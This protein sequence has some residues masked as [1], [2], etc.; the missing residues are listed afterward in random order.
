M[1]DMSFRSVFR[2]F[3]VEKLG[4]LKELCKSRWITD[5][6]MIIVI[7]VVVVVVVVVV[8]KY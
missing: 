6:M 4:C 3:H 2:C 7:V 8:S 5:K 1:E